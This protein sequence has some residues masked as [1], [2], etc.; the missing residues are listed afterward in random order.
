MFLGTTHKCPAASI[1]LFDQVADVRQQDAAL[2]MQ[3]LSEIAAQSIHNPRGFLD[4]RERP[5]EHAQ[6]RGAAPF[7]RCLS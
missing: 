3:F 5:V 2:G 7:S 6:L 4:T 1:I